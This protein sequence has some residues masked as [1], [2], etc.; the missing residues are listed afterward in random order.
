MK[1]TQEELAV[2]IQNGDESKIPE[3]W[4]TVQKLYTMKSYRYYSTHRA[5]CDRAGVELDDIQQYCFFAFLDAVKAY[6]SES[7]LLFLSYIDF[8]F[9][10]AMQELTQTRTTRQRLDALNTCTS[11]DLPIDQEDGESSGTLADLVP[12]PAAMEFVELLDAQS[13]GAMVR[14]E[15]RKLPERECTVIYDYYFSG[16]SLVEIGRK[17]SLSTER[18][19]CIRNNGLKILS[20]RRRLVELWNEYHHTERLRQL[21]QEQK[22]SEPCAFDAVRAYDRKTERQK[23]VL[24]LAAQY[25]YN[26]RESLGI[27]PADWSRDDQI[28]AILEYLHADPVSQ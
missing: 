23:T 3:L 1:H 27:S 25:A 7:D 26:K 21:E 14:A 18:V 15:V 11:L 16:L 8:P 9:Q 28:Q 12:D 20:R 6:K 5:A 24:D 4:D 19:R 13:V 17:L 10:T 2:M 22:H